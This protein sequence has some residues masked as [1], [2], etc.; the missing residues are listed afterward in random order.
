VNHLTKQAAAGHNQHLTLML[1]VSL[2]QKKG[3]E[4]NSFLFFIALASVAQTGTG[5]GHPG[6]DIGSI[7]SRP[8]SN[9]PF[10]RG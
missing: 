6:A 2:S 3:R 4:N 5:F 7:E 1:S 9:I 8:T 10:I